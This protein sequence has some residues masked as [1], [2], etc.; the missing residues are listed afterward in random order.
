M[1]IGSKI[2]GTGNNWEAYSG[3]LTQW[4]RWKIMELCYGTRIVILMV[5]GFCKNVTRGSECGKNWLDISHGV[6]QR[7]TLFR[8]ET[9]Y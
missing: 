5:K 8:A 7:V 2:F 1:L 9:I 3:T 6:G 4:H